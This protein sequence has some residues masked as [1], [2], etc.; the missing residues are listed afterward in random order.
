MN[1]FE[2]ELQRQPFREAPKAWRAEILARSAPSAREAAPWTWRDWFWPSPIAWA[3]LAASWL[4]LWEID[5]A[6]RPARPSRG[7]GDRPAQIA[8]SRETSP[9]AFAGRTPGNLDLD[10]LMALR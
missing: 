2:Q 6:D 7:E 9:L 5:R 10:A 8:G 3:G 1:D 4:L